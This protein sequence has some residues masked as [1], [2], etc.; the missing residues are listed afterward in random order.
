MSNAEFTTPEQHKVIGRPFPKGVSGNPAGRPKGSRQ[1]L[2]GD[3]LRAMAA[4]FAVHGVAASEKVR[5]EKPDIYLRIA[6]DLLPRELTVD[7]T[8]DVLHDAGSVL[9]CFRTMNALLGADPEHG[10]RR[11]K[12]LAP[13]ID[14]E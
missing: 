13:Q 6:A 8:V 14:H 10:M 12:R 2:A 5:A 7:A 3:F 9:E 4:D 1:I 11:L